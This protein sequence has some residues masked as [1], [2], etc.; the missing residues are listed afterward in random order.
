[1]H[2]VVISFCV[3]GLVINSPVTKLRSKL[4]KNA[5]IFM[6]IVVVFEGVYPQVSF[7][8]SMHMSYC[9]QSSLHQGVFATDHLMRRRVIS[10]LR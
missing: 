8:N 1:V 10:F 3:Q 5:T 7:D 9:L 6:S 2:S 4:A